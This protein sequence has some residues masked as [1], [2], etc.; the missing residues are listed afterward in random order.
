MIAPWGCSKS[1]LCE[2]IQLSALCNAHF[3][4]KYLV[5]FTRKILAEKLPFAKDGIKFA[6]WYDTQLFCIS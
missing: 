1:D 2:N 6:L 4:V 5:L 3:T